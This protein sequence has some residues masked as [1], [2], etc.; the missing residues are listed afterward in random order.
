[1]VEGPERGATVELGVDPVVVGSSAEAQLRLT[2]PRVS[3]RHLELK[4]GS[5][6]VLI[7][8]LSSRNGTWFEGSR[9]REIA[10]PPGA[11]LRVGDSWLT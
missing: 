6:A 7:T 4:A 5:H 8:D 9:M 11:L 1:M 2:D 10:L 3:R